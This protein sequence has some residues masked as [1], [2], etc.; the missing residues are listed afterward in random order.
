MTHEETTEQCKL[1]FMTHGETTGSCIG[2]Q[3]HF[4][5]L[6]IIGSIVTTKDVPWLNEINQMVNQFEK[7]YKQNQT[8]GCSRNPVFTFETEL[9]FISSCRSCF[10]PMELKQ[11]R[12]RIQ[13]LIRIL[14]ADKWSGWS[15]TMRGPVQ[16]WTAKS[17][18]CE[19]L[20]VRFR[21]LHLAVVEN[22]RRFKSL[23]VARFRGGMR[24]SQ[25][26][27]WE[28][29]ILPARDATD[30]VFLKRVI[31]G[32]FSCWLFW[33][34][35]CLE[36]NGMFSSPFPASLPPTHPTSLPLSQ[37]TSMPLFT[38]NVDNGLITTRFLHRLHNKN[39]LITYIG[40]SYEIQ[41]IILNI[42][43]DFPRV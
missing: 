32:K 23:Q 33:E 26:S 21:T 18:F 31:G 13:Y 37:V 5:F 8:D 28:V 25:R 9:D 19:I 14:K 34:R 7:E 35:W 38:L 2:F 12:S 16:S 43:E 41:S 11:L 24:G 15:W 20:R 22:L 1:N 10:I 6:K 4:P 3:N 29:N 40:V 30:A 42:A 17:K 39:P 36:C 27:E